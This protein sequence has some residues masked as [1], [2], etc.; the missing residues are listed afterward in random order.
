MVVRA[1]KGGR[2]TEM[3]VFI[4]GE[5]GGKRATAKTERERRKSRHNKK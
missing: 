1:R 5:S 4:G 3:R 2:P